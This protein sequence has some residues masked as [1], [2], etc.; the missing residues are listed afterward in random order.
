MGPG[1]SALFLSLVAFAQVQILFLQLPLDLLRLF[2]EVGDA[3]KGVQVELLVI[4]F[5]YFILLSD[6]IKTFCKYNLIKR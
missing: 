5:Q 3:V 4:L 6:K 2:N 1:F